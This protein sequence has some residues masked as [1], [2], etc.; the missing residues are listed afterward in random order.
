MVITF[1]RNVENHP[2]DKTFNSICEHVCPFLMML[3]NNCQHRLGIH[4]FNPYYDQPSFITMEGH[5]DLH[6]LQQKISVFS[7]MRYCNGKFLF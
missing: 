3:C 2:V 1:N 4:H 5:H 6:E 7:G